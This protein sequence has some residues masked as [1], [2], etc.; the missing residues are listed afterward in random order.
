MPVFI[1]LAVDR[2]RAG[3]T[4]AQTD[5]GVPINELSTLCT[6]FEPLSIQARRTSASDSLAHGCNQGQGVFH[7]HS[8]VFV[9]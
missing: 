5:L 2:L 6:F 1:I 9:L 7:D 4:H 8:H 3:C